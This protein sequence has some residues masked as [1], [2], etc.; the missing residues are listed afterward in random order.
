MEFVVV[1]MEVDRAPWIQIV[2]ND[3]D[4]MRINIVVTQFD[5]IRSVV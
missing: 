4:T 5:D 2:N 1:M 3:T